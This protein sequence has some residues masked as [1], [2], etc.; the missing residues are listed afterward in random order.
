MSW[1]LEFQKSLEQLKKREVFCFAAT[2]VAVDKVNGVCT[3]NDGELE[4]TDVRL[5][6]I[7]D[8][9]DQKCFV[10][11]K[12]GSS[13]LIEPINEDLKQLYVSKYSEVESIYGL[14]DTTKFTIDKNGFNISRNDENLKQ[15]LNDW[16]TEFGKLCDELSKVIVSIGTTP[17]VPVINDIKNTVTV[18]LKDRLNTILTA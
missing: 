1:E 7:I 8:G 13:V 4:L 5:S 9:N 10:F 3:I 2:V 16:Q 15:V 17:N 11:P 18:T 12:A 6:A 14:I